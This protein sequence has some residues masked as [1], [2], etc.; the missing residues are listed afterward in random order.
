[1]KNTKE[2][3]PLLTAIFCLNR[4]GEQE[5]KDITLLLDYAFR[6]FFGANTNLL[7]LTCCGK[8]ETVKTAVSQLLSQD[9]EYDKYLEEYK[10]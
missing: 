6:R 2:V 3:Q 4:I 5:N 1:M 10:K 7:T 9:T 8:K